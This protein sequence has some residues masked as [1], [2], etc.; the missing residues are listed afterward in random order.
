MLQNF[1]EII[2]VWILSIACGLPAIFLFRKNKQ[3]KFHLDVDGIILSF[4]CGLALTSLFASIICL[5][6]P[7]HYIQLLLFSLPFVTAS[8]VILKREIIIKGNNP[9]RKGNLPYI[10]VFFVTSLLFIALGSGRPVMEDT[11]LYHL[12][13][14]RW[15]QEYGTVVGIAN[16]FPKY[17]TY[18]NWLELTS[19]F[20]FPFA[21]QNFLFLNISLSILFCLYLLYKIA[22]H[23]KRTSDK[24]HRILT[25]LY[26]FIFLFMLLE[27]N[28]FRGTASSTNFDCIVTCL[29]VFILMTVVED[30]LFNQYSANFQLLPLILLTAA[31]PFFKMTGGLLLPAVFVYLIITKSRFKNYLILVGVIVVF[32]VPFVIRNYLQTGYL[33]YP[34]TV[35]TPFSPDWQLPRAM[36]NKHVDYIGLSNKF[37]NQSIPQQAWLS[38]SNASWTTGWMRRLTKFDFYLVSMTIIAAPIS[39]FVLGKRGFKQGKK[40]FLLYLA[41]FLGIVAWFF[42]APDPRFAYGLLLFSGFLIYATVLEQLAKKIFTYPLLLA[43]SLTAIIYSFGKLS[44]NILMNPSLIPSPPLKVITVNKINYSLPERINNNW[45]PRCYYVNV[46]CIYEMNPYLEARGLSIKNGFRMKKPDSSFV[47][48]YYY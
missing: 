31:I 37:L 19:L 1:F 30:I 43:A 4:F 16:L 9:F 45:N 32:G 5:I 44:A 29:V 46:P 12:Q 25:L 2:Y 22:Y 11:D 24:A 35:F 3:I 47:L 14:I 21:R 10:F 26:L 41:C 39:F 33:F 42:L 15:N 23:H 13:I 8:L 40:V 27:W 20:S 18:S 34:Y 17:G 38:P 36:A 28:L 6:F 7:L 48:H